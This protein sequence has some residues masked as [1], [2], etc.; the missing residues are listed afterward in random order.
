MESASWGT[1]AR[2]RPTVTVSFRTSAPR[3]ATRSCLAATLCSHN[4]RS[5]RPASRL[6]RKAGSGR[7]SRL[8]G[9]WAVADRAAKAAATAPAIATPR[10]DVSTSRSEG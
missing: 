9:C 1:S 5:P 3:Q 6:K 10:T 4:D 2:I 7:V 8:S